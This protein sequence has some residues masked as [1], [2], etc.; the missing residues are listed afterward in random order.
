M[1]IIRSW[2]KQYGYD[3]CIY[4]LHGVAWQGSQRLAVLNWEGLCMVIN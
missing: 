2:T 1:L 4:S 3:V